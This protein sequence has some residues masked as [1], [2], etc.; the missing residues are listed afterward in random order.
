MNESAIGE[1]H[2]K[3]NAMPGR[4]F[5]CDCSRFIPVRPFPQSTDRPFPDTFSEV[6]GHQIANVSVLWG[7]QQVRQS[8]AYHLRTDFPSRV[9]SATASEYSENSGI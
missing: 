2:R 5:H 9:P 1:P 7:R 8:L 4:Q 3:T 6:R